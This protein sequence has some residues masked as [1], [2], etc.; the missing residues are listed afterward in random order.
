MPTEAGTCRRFVVPVLQVAGWDNDP[1]SIAKQRYFTK[2]RIVVG[3][4][5]SAALPRSAAVLGCEL[6]HRPGAMSK[7][8]RRDAAST[9]SRGLPRHLH[10]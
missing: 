2:G 7:T 9:R 5:P 3:A 4:L 8:W 6:W 10:A 1:H